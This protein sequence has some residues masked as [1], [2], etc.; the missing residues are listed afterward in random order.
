MLL[1]AFTTF[2]S[3]F[4]VQYSDFAVPFTVPFAMSFALPFS[5]DYFFQF[6]QQSSVSST[7]ACKGKH[8]QQVT[9]AGEFGKLVAYDMRAFPRLWGDVEVQKKTSS[10]D[11]QA[12]PDRPVKKS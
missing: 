3:V 1:H 12:A 5:F 8:H 11:C 7:Y 2:C 9:N 6:F 4:G 10:S